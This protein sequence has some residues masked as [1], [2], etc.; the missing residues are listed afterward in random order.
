MK[1]G[2]DGV[3]LGAW[4]LSDRYSLTTSETLNETNPRKI[5][6]VG[7]G[8][9]LI[10][11]MM[12]QRFPKAEIK[13]IEIDPVAAEE[14]IS[15]FNSS[16]W[17]NRLSLLEGDFNNLIIDDHRYDLIVSNPPFFTNGALPPDSTRLLARHE[18][19]LTID[20]LLDHSQQLLSP[21][22]SICVILPA[23]RENDLKFKATIYHLELTRLTRVSTVPRKPPQ[24]I[25][26]ELRLVNSS[27][28]PLRLNNISVHDSKG[29]FTDE[30]SSLVKDFYLKF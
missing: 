14:A 23:D 24:R 21:N 7:S 3:L 15:N 2:T 18:S 22:G 17:N 8:T 12:A 13:A 5:L 27:P 28:N 20:S 10:A 4:C 19:S 26:A 16:P 1:V 29:G 9:G 6:D 30:Y 25:L 11:L